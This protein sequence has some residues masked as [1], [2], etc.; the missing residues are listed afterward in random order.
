MAR[1]AS[2]LV[3]SVLALALQAMGQAPPTKNPAAH[4]PDVESPASAEICGDCHRGAQEGWK[5]S[6]H[7]HA[8]DSRVFQDALYYAER[9]LDAGA[10]EMCLGCHAP[11]AAATSDPGLR[12]KVAWEGVTCDYCHSVRDVSLSGP[13]PRA[14]MEYTRERTGPWKGESPGRHGALASELHQSSLLCASCHE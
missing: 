9:D 10:R 2:R 1:Y 4:A 13:N 14:R 5:A 8:V 6:G 12:T 7:A 3:A 11:L